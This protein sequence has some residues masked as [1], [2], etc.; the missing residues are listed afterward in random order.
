MTTAGCQNASVAQA[1]EIPSGHDPA[2]YVTTRIM[3]TS[4]DGAQMPV[5]ILHARISARRQRTA[6]AL[7]LR[8]YGGDAGRFPP[9]DCRC[10]PWFV[11]AI[12]FVRS[13]ADRGWGWYLDGKREE[14][15][16]SMTLRRRSR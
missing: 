16:C 8:L 5:S 7:R 11:Y 4:H 9:T 1:P 15:N 10:R 12:P 3:A 14:T 13:G 2:N 6:V